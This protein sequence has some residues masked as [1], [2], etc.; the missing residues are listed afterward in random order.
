MKTR[1]VSWLWLSLPVVISLL[2]FRQTAPP[3]LR[4]AEPVVPPASTSAAAQKTAKLPPASLPEV[5]AAIKRVFAG[6]V[7]LDTAH[8]PIFIT[9]DLNCDCSEDLAVVVHPVPAR[10]ADLNSEVANWIVQDALS[11]PANYIHVQAGQELLVVI[12]GY[13]AKGWRTS[14]AQQTY[15][16]LNAVG[17]DMRT[18]TTAGLLAAMHTRP[19]SIRCEALQEKVG[20][21][22][23]YLFW[24]GAR[25]IWRAEAV[26]ARLHALARPVSPHSMQ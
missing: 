23:G 26:L 5:R 12:H 22:P 10:L 3:Q 25:Y 24:G 20:G 8:I 14:E 15:V 17:Q 1:H 2:A 19:A 18:T 7:Q 9:A 11:S 6:A 4:E 21:E 16:L 13:G